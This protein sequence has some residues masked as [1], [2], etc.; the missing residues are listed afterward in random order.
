MDATG[1]PEAVVDEIVAAMHLAP[2]GRHRRQETNRHGR[3]DGEE[4]DDTGRASGGATARAWTRPCDGARLHGRAQYD[5]EL[6]DDWLETI[7]RRAADR[8]QAER[9]AIVTVPTVARRYAPL[10]TRGLAARGA[11]V[12]R[13]VVPDGDATKNAPP[14]AGRAL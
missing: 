2:E 10:L 14:P 12:A 6:G 4:E 8:L 11:K 13:I 1:A 7:G 9:V 5:V 3:Q